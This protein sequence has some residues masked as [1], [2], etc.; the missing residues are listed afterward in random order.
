[1]IQYKYNK[2]IYTKGCGFMLDNSFS[3]CSNENCSKKETCLRYTSKRNVKYGQTY[4]SL[5][6]EQCNK[7]KCYINKVEYYK[8][9]IINIINQIPKDDLEKKMLL[10]SCNSLLDISKQYNLY[11]KLQQKI[12][13]LEN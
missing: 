7:N 11:E 8:K 10:Q 12:K 5:T 13:E 2:I 6:E 1:M 4:L 3:Y 9:M